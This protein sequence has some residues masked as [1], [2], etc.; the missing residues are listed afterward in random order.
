L[1]SIATLAVQ[2]VANASNLTAGLEKTAR[3]VQRWSDGVV[4][5]ISSI[6]PRVGKTL[7]GFL[8]PLTAPLGA[9]G[10][11][12]NSL[13]DGL[14]SIPLIGSIFAVIPTSIKGMVDSI[15]QE[16]D[17]MAEL[18]HQSE[19]TG[20]SIGMLAALQ[21]K[22]DP[23][24]VEKGLSM[25]NR[26]LAEAAQGSDEAQ[27]KFAKLGLDWKA[28]AAVGVD[29]RL[30]ML[31]DQFAQ[32]G[33]AEQRA[34]VAHELF[35]KSGP[36]WLNALGNG[37]EKLQNMVRQADRLG[38]SF[39]ALEAR[40]MLKAKESL[41]L[42]DS[43]IEGIQRRMAIE[44]APIVAIIAEKFTDWVA[45]MGGFRGVWEAVAKTVAGF[46]AIALKGLM[47]T[48]EALAEIVKYL[49]DIKAT[50]KDLKEWGTNVAASAGGQPQYKP[51]DRKRALP[52]SPSDFS[53]GGGGAPAAP[54]GQVS[55]FDWMFNRKPAAAVGTLR[56]GVE[57]LIGTLEKISRGGA[58]EWFADLADK[59]KELGKAMTLPNVQ[60][61]EIGK[62]SDELKLKMEAEAAAFGMSGEA[63]ERMKLAQK[64]Q[65]LRPQ[66]AT[67]EQLKPFKDMEGKLADLDAMIGQMKTL[68]EIMEAPVM[69][70]NGFD[71]LTQRVNNLTAALQ[72]GKIKAEANQAALG[73]LVDMRVKLEK[74]KAAELFKETRT[75]LE[76]LQGKL[77]EL[78]EL[79]GRGAISDDLF[80]RGVGGAF[81]SLLG[82][83]GEM[84]HPAASQFGSQEAFKSVLEYQ[85]AGDKSRTDPVE[86]VRAAIEL[87]T[88]I[89]KEQLN[90]NKQ[91]AE[92]VKGGLIQVGG[93]L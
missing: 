90:V 16:I 65:G 75:P 86:K 64:L 6:G 87:Q 79:Q 91:I 81:Q 58:A 11:M 33:A 42:M 68:R 1:A 92:A 60:L 14:K 31:A 78:K 9:L 67:E 20:A 80:N 85:M 21:M 63:V 39:S 50:L 2:L 8:S 83:Q 62:K 40:G 23:A 29:Q 52:F 4:N 3:Q 49:A 26:T 36:Q 10:T 17:T 61:Q 82:H 32:M 84:R 22:L 89:Q 70:G 55:P 5:Q 74:T 77:A 34:M 41:K 37:S 66:G 47:G 93:P 27:A 13:M 57:S 24:V 76:A 35:S 44:L 72:G 48:I 73:K 54:S 25:F 46:L 18:A 28:L 7:G 51:P 71:E 15:R 56:E 38:L 30:G 45:S 59:G 69:A 88:Q 43:A 53:F 12:F 19:R